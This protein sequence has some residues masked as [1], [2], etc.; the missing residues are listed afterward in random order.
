MWANREFTPKACI[1]FHWLRIVDMQ[2]TKTP[3]SLTIGKSSRGPVTMTFQHIPVCPDGFLMGSRGY[4]LYEEPIHR[5]VIPENFWLGT[6]L[7]TQE[8]FGVWTKAK[9]IKHK[10]YF[11]GNPDHPAEEMTWHQAVEYCDWL[12]KKFAKQMP[13]GHRLATLPAE[14]Q[15][16]C[17]CRGNSQ[18][19]YSNGDGEAAL[20]EVGWYEENA[21]NC[22]KPVRERAAN[23]FGLHDMHGNVWEWCL[24]RWD[25]EA[26]RKR[27]DGI[28]GFETYELNEQYGDQSE[29]PGRVLR[30]GSWGDTAEWCRSACRDRDRAGISFR[31]FGFRVCLV[32]SPTS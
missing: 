13:E 20:A 8:Q 16:E 27:W 24:D 21:E 23:A 10:N 32:R 3:F 12:T 31:G 14:A 28:T 11:E 26:Y 2:E 30:G 1:V 7:V 17:A 22:T 15:W 25:S 5:V 9:K 6:T 29:D 18:T 4:Y 19:E